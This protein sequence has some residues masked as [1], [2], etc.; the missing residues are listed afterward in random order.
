[1]GRKKGVQM[2]K[3]FDNLLNLVQEADIDGAIDE[4]KRAVAEGADSIEY[5]QDV[6]APVMNN[7]GDQFSRMEIFLPDL[8]MAA[9][10]ADGIRI[11]LMKNI[12]VA[13]DANKGKVVI[14]TI[15]GDNH[16][17]GKKMVATL[18]GVNGYEILDL[19]TDVDPMAFINAVKRDKVNVVAMSSLLSTGMPYVSET[20]EM[21][22]ALG[23][24][25]Q[26]KVIVGGGPVNQDWA[27]DIGA[28]GYAHDAK[29]AVD[30]LDKLLA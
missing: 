18:L 2:D 10:A 20:I 9:E 25:D 15:S 5:L 27:D 17:I 23:L 8:M 22:V 7:L 28:D 6:L 19:G 30:M 4:A 21:L 14:G 1:M 11:E 16:D 3:L 13:S 24:R 12:A 26:C 29:Q